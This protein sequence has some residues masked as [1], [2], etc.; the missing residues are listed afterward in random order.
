MCRPEGRATEHASPSI[1]F[2]G[3]L[4]FKSPRRGARSAIGLRNSKGKEDSDSSGMPR[5]F[6]PANVMP[7]L[8]AMTGLTS[9]VA[10][11]VICGH[12][13]ASPS[14]RLLMNCRAGSALSMQQQKAHECHVVTAQNVALNVR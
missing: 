1:Q 9:H 12:E 14:I 7:M 3:A 2:S 8:R 6:R 4:S 5:A 11:G 13:F 10:A